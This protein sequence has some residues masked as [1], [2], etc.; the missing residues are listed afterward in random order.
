MSLCIANAPILR[1]G[2]GFD[3][4]K[5]KLFTKFKNR[6]PTLGCMCP[7]EDVVDKNPKKLLELTSELSDIIQKPNVAA[8]IASNAIGINESSRTDATIPPWVEAMMEVQLQ[9]FIMQPDIP[10]HHS[11]L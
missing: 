7:Q 6:P 3:L 8:G 11:Q 5:P 2:T 4:K 9:R 10:V 1:K